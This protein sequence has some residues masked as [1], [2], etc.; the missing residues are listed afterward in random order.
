MKK[1][2]SKTTLP[3]SLVGLGFTPIH[4]VIGAFFLLF[5]AASAVTVISGTTLNFRSELD[6]LSF[7][8]P[9]GHARVLGAITPAGRQEA[10]TKALFQT[11]VAVVEVFNSSIIS[12]FAFDPKH[13]EQTLGIRIFVRKSG[14][15]TANFLTTVQANVPRPDLVSPQ[16]PL[17]GENTNHGFNIQ[18]PASLKSGDMIILY[19]DTNN[20]FWH[21]MLGEWP[22]EKN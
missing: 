1:L 5:I 16:G 22:L 12:G 20:G 21:P 14:K 2:I 10:S 11:P 4:S 6:G 18:T 9:T 7:Q 15:D 17:P 13:P 19:A 8:P 3:I